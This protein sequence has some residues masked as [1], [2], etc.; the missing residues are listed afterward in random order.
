[1]EMSLQMKGNG[2]AI[3]GSIFFVIALI[4]VYRSFYNMRIPVE[5]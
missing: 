2:T 3:L 4:F 5:K 1:M